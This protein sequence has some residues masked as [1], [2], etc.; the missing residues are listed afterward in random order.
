VAIRGSAG[1]FRHEPVSLPCFCFRLKVQPSHWP[2]KSAKDANLNSKFG[3]QKA[4]IS[5]FVSVEP[6]SKL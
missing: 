5:D 3:K 2:Q 6:V 4:E 1:S